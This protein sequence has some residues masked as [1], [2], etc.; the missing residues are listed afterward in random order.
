MFTFGWGEIFLI[1]III[2][3]VIGPKDLPKF[4]K[5]IGLLAKNIR[6]ISSDFKSS[7]N[8]I[9]EE[10]EIKDLAKSVKEVK[11]IK[12]GINIKK[13]F[14]KEL[15]IVEE[16]VKDVKK[17]I[18]DEETNLVKET[19]KDVEKT[20]SDDESNLVEETVTDVENNTSN[21]DN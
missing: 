12:D 8:E 16:T 13:N 4:I 3:V 11:K 6:K 15:N 10:T 18:S 7:I 19:V 21:K 20:I 14:Q 1:G 2:V 5:Q 9:A 17:N